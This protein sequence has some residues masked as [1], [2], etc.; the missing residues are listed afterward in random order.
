MTGRPV[1]NNSLR[2]K[3][4][5]SF[6]K[7]FTASGFWFWLVLAFIS[8]YFL[9][10]IRQKIKFGIDLVGGTYITLRV[11][12]DKAVEH[13][14]R[15]K[16]QELEVS[17]KNSEKALPSGHIFKD[18]KLEIN[19]A[20]KDA[21]LDAYSLL[22]REVE[23]LVAAV[24]DKNLVMSFNNKKENEI[25]KGA[26]TGDI[27]V[28]RTRLNTIGAEEIKVA[29]QGETDI[30]IE[31]PDVPSGM[32]ILPFS[33]VDKKLYVLV[34]DY[35]EISGR[36]LKDAK[37]AIGGQYGTEAVV[38]FKLTG[39]GA[40][41][42]YELT[43]EN[44]GKNLAII[45]DNKV[46]SAPVI[47]QGIRSEGQITGSRSMESAK[48]LATLLKSGAFVAPVKF[49]EE[50]SVGPSLG[51]E[52]IK[53]GVISCLV[54][55]ILLFLFSIIVYKLSGFFAFLALIYNLLLMLLAMSLF[56]A[57]LTLPGIA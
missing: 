18:S 48:E 49:E 15:E 45:L 46:I 30:I 4:M 56:K 57:T 40:K 3:F 22:K 53:S 42:F 52:S 16:L 32:Q 10:P 51:Y 43:S 44:I 12:T 35:A 8:I 37:A 1:Y 41:K 36:H 38:A 50:R 14:L 26:V 7:R 19:F 33:E 54:G 5:N 29:P 23:G 20:D 39:S 11:Q 6:S 28:L 55:F 31:L 9:Y 25:K 24:S 34:P 17:L 21:A 47:Q 2:R 13:E 27:E